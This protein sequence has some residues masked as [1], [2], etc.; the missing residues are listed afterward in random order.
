M[1]EAHFFAELFVF[2]EF[3]RV[4]VAK[5][6]KMFAGGLEILPEGEDVGS[7]SSQILHGGEDFVF[8]FAQAEHQTGFRG[9]VGVGFLGA[10]KEFKRALV[11]GTFAD[12]AIEA[13]NGFGVVI[14]N[15]RLD[16]QNLAKSVP[17]AAKIGDEHFYFAAGNA[18][19]NFLDGAGEDG[20]AT[21][22][23]V[24][25]IDAGDHGVT[26]AHLSHRLGDAER[27]ILV[28]R[29]DRFAGRDGAKAA[30]A[31]ADVAEDH[32]GSGAMFPT[33]THVGAACGFTNGVEI[34]GAHDALEVLIAFAAEEFDAEPVRARMS[35]GRGNQRWRSVG[36][37]VEGRGHEA[38]VYAEQAPGTNG[39]NWFEAELQHGNGQIHR[40]C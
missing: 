23:L 19:A 16:G 15:V 3:I 22:G 1:L 21:I 38:L 20:C 34:E 2:G 29:A 7:L 8:F 24:V 9:H 33:F 40:C 30:S 31:G 12:L 18:I 32:E 6:R 4:D 10:A 39:G 14:Q 35:P 5:N 17:V 28:R 27:F 36:D 13:R 25:T 11:D 26:Q 37:D